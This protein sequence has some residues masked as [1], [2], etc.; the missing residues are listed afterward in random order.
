MIN[1][2]NEDDLTPFA[3]LMEK[4]LKSCGWDSLSNEKSI[5][6]ALIR[7]FLPFVEN[8]TPAELHWYI[9][10]FH[11]LL[12]YN[13]EK[14]S[15]PTKIKNIEEDYWDTT[16]CEKLNKN[17]CTV[18]YP[19]QKRYLNFVR[20][21]EFSAQWNWNCCKVIL[22]YMG[23]PFF[24]SLLSTE[25]IYSE[26]SK[27]H[28]SYPSGIINIRNMKLLKYDTI[29]S[30][31]VNWWNFT[32]FSVQKQ[33][34]IAKQLLLPIVS[35]KISDDGKIAYVANEANVAAKIVESLVDNLAQLYLMIF[36]INL[37]NQET[38]KALSRFLYA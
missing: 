23:M 17:F 27:V 29:E 37:I 13:K 20:T 19:L 28:I 14:P 30:L 4:L 32:K 3:M 12:W 25:K 9:S 16:S 2:S 15:Q 18:L 31:K 10:I 21:K 22:D 5:F 24:P 36:D 38:D 1:Q 26:A 6:Y 35:K 34:E 8:F 7:A 33:Q 11:V